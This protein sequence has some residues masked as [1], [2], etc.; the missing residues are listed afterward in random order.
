[1]WDKLVAMTDQILAADLLDASQETALA[2]AIEAGVIA[3][4]A[5]DD[6]SSP[7]GASADELSQV[8]R[9]GRAAWEG[10]LLANT[11]LVQML[12]AREARRAGLDAQDLFQEGFV[13]LAKALQRYDYRRGRFA[14]YAIPRIRHEIAQAA[15]SRLGALGLP[16][17]VA[18]ARRRLVATAGRLDQ[19]HQ[20]TTSFDEL[21]ESVG[22][23]AQWASRVLAHTAPVPLHEHADSLPDLAPTRGHASDGSGELAHHMGRL[24]LE[25]HEILRLR[26]GLGDDVPRSY[27]A[28]A[29]HVGRSATSVRRIEKRALGNLRQHLVKTHR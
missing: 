4:A 15:S 22:R 14:T 13:A 27:A 7:G 24:T 8:A 16:A 3:Q 5:L 11:R 6:G 29:A 10:F 2:R 1:M 18:I 9:E 20:R 17:S 25:E 28:V 12:A 26:F 21:S 23:S 19:E